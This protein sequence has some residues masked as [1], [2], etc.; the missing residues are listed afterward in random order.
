MSKFCFFNYQK[1]AHIVIISLIMYT[2]GV[3]V[4]RT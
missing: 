3:N 4:E 1:C 2:E